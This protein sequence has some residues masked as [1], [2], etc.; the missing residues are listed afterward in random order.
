MK[1]VMMVAAGSD[2][3]VVGMKDGRVWAWGKMAAV[4]EGDDRFLWQR[5]DVTGCCGE[6]AV[7]DLL[8]AGT[9]YTCLYKHKQNTLRVFGNWAKFGQK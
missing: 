1:D 9:D 7:G 5:E 2:H 8:Q 4:L 3:G 6:V